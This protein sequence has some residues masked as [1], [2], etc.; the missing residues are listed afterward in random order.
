MK[1]HLCKTFFVFL[2]LVTGAFLSAQTLKS[3]S[4]P[5]FDVGKGVVSLLEGWEFSRDGRSWEAVR[6]PHD[7]AIGGEFSRTNDLQ[8]VMIIQDG[9]RV[10]RD[11]T[12][13][14]GGLP[15]VGEGWYRRVVLLPETVKVAE[16]VFDGAMSNPTVFSDGVK[17]GGCESGYAP[18]VVTFLF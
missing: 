14:T 4:E 11:H 3:R 1:S 12:G 18:F 15:W 10:A 8:H 7:W 9:E 17:I 6:I 13:R 16:L 5:L 2:L